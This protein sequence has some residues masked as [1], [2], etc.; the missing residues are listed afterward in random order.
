LYLA[1]FVA[2]HNIPFKIMKHM[3]QLIKK[4]CVYSEIAKNIACSRTKVIAI[5]RNVLG[6]QFRRNM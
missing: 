1:A 6:V 2:E 4:I 3:P 5:V